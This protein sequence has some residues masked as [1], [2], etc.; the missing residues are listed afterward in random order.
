[1]QGNRANNVTATQIA[2]MVFCER[3][4]VQGHSYVKSAAGERKR[5]AGVRAHKEF[6]EHVKNNAKVPDAVSG[7]GW[8]HYIGWT[9]L[10]VSV[11]SVVGF[12]YVTTQV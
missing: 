10:L 4:V 2:S 5:Q 8:G 11:L 12:L 3:N 9:V 7:T 1:M 6:E